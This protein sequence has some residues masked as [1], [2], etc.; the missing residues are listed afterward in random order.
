MDNKANMFGSKAARQYTYE[1]IAEQPDGSH[2]RLEVSR[3]SRRAAEDAGY[4][5]EPLAGKPAQ[6]IARRLYYPG[7]RVIEF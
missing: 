5:M 4:R 6:I 3:S 7:G 1:V 2:Y